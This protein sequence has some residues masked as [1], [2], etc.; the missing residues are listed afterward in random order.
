MIH[1]VDEWVAAAVSRQRLRWQSIGL[2][3]YVG[4]NVA[5]QFAG[6]PDALASLLAVLTTGGLSLE[7]VTVELTESESLREDDRLVGFLAGLHDAGVTVA[8]DDFGRAYSSLDRLREVPARW[9]KLDRAFVERVP[10]DPDATGVLSAILELVAALGLDMIVEGIER[11]EQLEVLRERGNVKLAQGFLL[12]R[13]LPAAELE[14]RLRA[15]PPSRLAPA[16]I[17]RAA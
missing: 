3:P 12:G 17:P 15:A 16:R 8:L 11:A 9:V 2:D 6:R 10:G 7:K 13:P 1:A 4:F 14:E 5:P